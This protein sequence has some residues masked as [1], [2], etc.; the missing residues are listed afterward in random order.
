MP[1]LKKICI[2]IPP[3]KRIGLIAHDNQ[4]GELLEWA[5]YNKNVLRA[6]DLFATGTTGRLHH[7]L[8]PDVHRVQPDRGRFRLLSRGEGAL[9]PFA[10]G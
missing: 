6:H 10:G 9:N 4:K 3:R 5:E 2:P 8:S 7:L 1:T